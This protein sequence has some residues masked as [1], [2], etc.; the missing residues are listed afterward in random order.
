MLTGK[1]MTLQVF[2]QSLHRRKTIALILILLILSVTLFF[3]LCN[4]ELTVKP[5][6][7]PVVDAVYA[8]GTVKTDKWYNARFGMNTIIKKLY[9]NE[10][11]NVEKGAHLVLGDTPFPLTAPFP[12]IVTAI[13]YRETEMAA[14]GQIVLTI[15][16]L[17]NLY[18]KVTLDQ[19]SIVHVRKGQPVEMSFENLR[20]EKIYGRVEAVYLS[21]EDF[22]VR[23]SADKFPAGVLPQM[24]CDAAITIRKKDNAVIIPLAAYREGKVNVIRKGKR[25]NIPVTVRRIDS[26]KAEV[27][28]DSIL[29]DDRIIVKN[30]GKAQRD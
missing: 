23:I 14:S 22:A 15:S 12:G 17:V 2:S 7:G 6:V 24:T 16:S 29:P 20:D 9:V 21:G 11:D 1:I 10:G 3:N 4:R 27:L 8:L 28:D 26:V 13:N 30:S 19:E 5:E 25:I 18:V